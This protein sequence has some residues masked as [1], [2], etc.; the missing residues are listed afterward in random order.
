MTIHDE[1]DVITVAI[2]STK[3]KARDPLAVLIVRELRNRN[4]GPTAGA[5]L[6]GLSQGLVSDLMIGNYRNISF[7]R[8]SMALGVLGFDVEMTVRRR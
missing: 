1:G 5:R 3:E 6:L 4:L 8:A 7:E 2:D